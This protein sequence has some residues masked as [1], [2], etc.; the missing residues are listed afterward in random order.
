MIFNDKW[1]KI[2][3]SDPQKA[4]LE[5][6]AWDGSKYLI[7]G[8]VENINTDNEYVIDLDDV[9]YTDSRYDELYKQ[10]VCN[11]PDEPAFHN[12]IS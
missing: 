7:T 10:L 4:I 2:G 1:K 3:D 12:T 11:E 9:K 6:T 8:D 5:Q